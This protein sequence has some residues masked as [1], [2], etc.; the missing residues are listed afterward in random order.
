MRPRS[1]IR[2]PYFWAIVGGVTLVG[3]AWLGR[4]RYRPVMTGS[5]APQF[6]ATTMEGETVTLADYGE[7]VVLL[8]IWATWCGPCRTEM[9]SMQ[10]LY[11]GVQGATNGEDFEILA[12]SIDVPL[13]QRDAIGNLG[14]DLRAFA[15]ELDLTFPILHD[16]SGDI[17]RT[18]QATA[19]P[20]SFLIGKDGTIYKQVAGQ[21]EWDAPDNQELVHRL[22]GY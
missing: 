21:T 19:V 10:R 4:E 22:L 5:V 3:V 8:N 15:E 1:T 6:S 13:G 20:E 11:D 18:Y 14:G 9:P 2:S 7:K 12:V 16:P 17:R